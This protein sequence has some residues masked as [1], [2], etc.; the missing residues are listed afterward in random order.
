MGREE[1]NFYSKIV[2]MDTI[3]TYLVAVARSLRLSE[4]ELSRIRTSIGNLQTK[5]DNWFG[6][7]LIKHFQFGSST[8]DTILPRRVDNDSDIDYMMPMLA[9]I[10]R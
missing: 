9:T 1:E 7:D 4:D 3:N 5:L 2:F 6:G 8:R 10:V